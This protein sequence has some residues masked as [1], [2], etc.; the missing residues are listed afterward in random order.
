MFIRVKYCLYGLSE[1]FLGK[2]EQK[3]FVENMCVLQYAKN[4]VDFLKKAKHF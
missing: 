2:D 3:V 1:E 4:V